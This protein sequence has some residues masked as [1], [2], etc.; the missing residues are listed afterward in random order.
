MTAFTLVTPPSLEPVTLDEAKAQARVDASA[1]DALIT[2]LIVAARQWAE[3]YTGSA[4]IT[5]G[6]Q[7]ALD[8]HE[9]TERFVVLP[10]PPLIA[11]TGVQVFDDADVGA[12]WPAGNY[13][14]DAA[15]EPARLALRSGATWPVPARM[16]NGIVVSYNAGYGASGAAVPEAIKLAIKQLAAHW[17]E[18]RGEA[19]VVPTRGAATHVPLVIQALLD[20]YRV[21]RLRV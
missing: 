19:V 7:L 21:Q 8:G 12:A 9:L 15:H 2:A 5:Q 17:Y 14:V 3:R 16:N 11:V 18:H 13:F 6:W 20:P 10:R 1:D 4:F